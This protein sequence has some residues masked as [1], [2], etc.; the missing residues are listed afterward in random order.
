[1]SESARIYCR[2]RCV[3]DWED[4]RKS[5]NI[6]GAN[7]IIEN[8]TKRSKK[9]YTFS[10]VFGEN[11]S[12][13]Q[14]FDRICSPL[15]DSVIDGHN[16][17][18]IAYGQTGSGKT[19][20]LVGKPEQNVL[21]LLPRALQRFYQIPSVTKVELIAT[22]AYGVHVARIEIFDLFSAGAAPMDWNEKRGR[23]VFSMSQAE[24]VK[25]TSMADAASRINQAHDSSHWACT[26]KNPESSRGHT[27]FVIKVE[28]ES[29]DGMDIKVSY[30]VVVDLA[31]SEGESAITKEFIAKNNPTTVMVRRLEAGCINAGLCQLQLIFSELKRRGKLSKVVGNG[32]RRLLHPFINTNTH[33]SVLF[34]VAPTIKNSPITD[35]TLKFAVQAGMVKVKPIA[36][37]AKKNIKALV[38]KLEKTCAEQETL[39]SQYVEDLEDKSGYIQELEN[40]VEHFQNETIRLTEEAETAGVSVHAPTNLVPTP[41]RQGTHHEHVR[42]ATKDITDELFKQVQMELD[43]LY[44]DEEEDMEEAGALSVPTLVENGATVPQMASPASSRFTLGSLVEQQR[45][46]PVVET[47]AATEE[48]V[49]EKVALNRQKSTAEM[50]LDRKIYHRTQN[51][52]SIVFEQNIM[53][54]LGI[55]ETAQF[56]DEEEEAAGAGANITKKSA[57]ITSDD[58]EDDE[59][60]FDED[61]LSQNIEETED[62]DDLEGLSV[63][64]LIE[65]ID[66]FKT[67]LNDKDILIEQYKAS[68]QIMMNHLSETNEAMFNFFK[69][70]Y[71]IPGQKQDKGSGVYRG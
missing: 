71:K 48:V 37:G 2:V 59:F 5:V 63:E 15:V 57:V 14:L 46:T 33:I 67:I 51:R 52:N 31:G 61:I 3:F 30:F 70:R 55:L 39:L 18:L 21:G 53:K 49:S 24:K 23:T 7:R 54:H 58:I 19:H 16:A 60:M 4:P 66:S 42:T 26:A 36:A 45:Q 20:S 27:V 32:L 6:T 1:M 41:R 8:Q 11:S 50:E 65:K 25:I 28:Q 62:F 43:G 40:Q 29:E 9:A 10:H 35:S 34:T 68:Q 12:N 64:E 13:E 38:K 44:E 47:E 22:E 69:I 56:M 17:V